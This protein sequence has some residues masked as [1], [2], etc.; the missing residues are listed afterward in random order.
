MSN[1]RFKDAIE[2]LSRR[3]FLGVPGALVLS[4]MTQDA[5][6]AEKIKVAAVITEYWYYSHADWIIGKLLEGYPYYGR[7][8]TPRVEVVSMYV[9]QFPDNDMSR[10]M[11]AKHSVPIYSTIRDALTM[12]TR[13]LAVDGVVF[14]GEHGDYHWNLKEQKLYPRWYL[15]KQI[16]DTFRATGRSVPVFND[17]HLSVDWNEAKW[18]YDQSRELD[19]P[20]MAG[21]SVP[22]SWRKPELELDMETPI[23]KVVVV[24]YGGKESYGFHSLEVLQ[25]MVER[26][27]G[28]ETG[29]AAVQCIEGPQ[30]WEWTDANPW[31]A[32][33]LEEALERLPEHKKGSPRDIVRHP[34]VFILEYRDGLRA[35]VYTLSGY[36]IRFWSFAADIL[37]KKEPVS[38]QFWFNFSPGR[39]LGSVNFVYYIEE[40]MVTRRESYPVERT[41][42]TTGAL[43]FLIESNY[44]NGRKFLEGR[45]IETPHLAIKYRAQKESL[46]NRG[47]RPPVEEQ[48]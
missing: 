34:I 4:G 20:F 8:H 13:D 35:A 42:L 18:M 26:R 11:A 29:I 36:G 48:K 3:E 38:T 37:G 47:P 2:G 30:V 32:R 46:F 27:K 16:V 45:R 44:E 22:L 31:A 6:A 19:F 21:S 12:G 43:S 14:I 28:G 33:L 7:E 5:M 25:C 39:S 1:S 24:G 17:K 41:L 40:L 23:E 15:Y 10:G 9:D